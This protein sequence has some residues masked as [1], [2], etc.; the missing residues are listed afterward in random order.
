M[1][2][3]RAG[4]GAEGPPG[5]IRQA[6]RTAIKGLFH[7]SEGERSGQVGVRCVCF[8]VCVRHSG[9]ENDPAAEAATVVSKRSSGR[10]L[11]RR[12]PKREEV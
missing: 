8:S 10:R 7:A 12:F 11:R 1:D 3:E 4:G 2:W 9:R 6:G 5:R